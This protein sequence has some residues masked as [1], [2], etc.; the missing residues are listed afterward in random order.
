MQVEYDAMSWILLQCSLGAKAAQDSATHK[1]C[2][3]KATVVVRDLATARMANL[4]ALVGEGLTL[5]WVLF[6]LV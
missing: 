4:S 2:V 6:V 1:T 3:V 5:F